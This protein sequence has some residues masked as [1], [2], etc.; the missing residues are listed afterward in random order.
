LF[1]TKIKIRGFSRVAQ[2]IL[3]FFGVC[4]LA[5]SSFVFLRGRVFQAIESREFSR[6]VQA[7]AVEDPRTVGT[8]P[9]ARPK[10]QAQA[11]GAV[12]GSLAIPRLGL[13]TIVVE[14]A[15]DRELKLAAGHIPGTSL[16]G[17]AGNVGI[18]A[19]RDTF[20]RPL[21]RI[22]KDDAIVLTTLNGKFGY[23]VVSTDIVTPDD[24]QV[25]SPAKTET[26]TLVT[27]YPF[28]FVGSAPQRFIVRAQR[29]P[30]SD[31][32]EN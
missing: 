18:A 15:G 24:V 32:S 25:L 2:Y 10:P 8:R 28:N 17:Q 29:F 1:Q 13:S 22:R 19:H 3:V 20:F 4:A 11:K 14:G 31:R 27:C 12:I 16:P 5:Y 6:A 9:T 7:M 21:R 23:R 30:A 26:L